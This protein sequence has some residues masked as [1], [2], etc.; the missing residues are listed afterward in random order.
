MYVLSAPCFS[1]AYYRGY[2]ASG[3]A[4]THH[5]SSETLAVCFERIPC[6][7]DAVVGEDGAWVGV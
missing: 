4:V 5:I 2:S 6:S 3:R 1:G 7:Y